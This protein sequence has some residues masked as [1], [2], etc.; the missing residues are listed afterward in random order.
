VVERLGAEL[1]DL[2]G[3]NLVGLYVYGSLAFGCYNPARS[4]VDVLV[5]TRRRMAAETLPTLSAFLNT[6]SDLEISFLSRADLDPWRLPCPY[7]Y[8]YSH[9]TE[10]HDGEN[11]DLAAEV[12]NARA[13]SVPLAGPPADSLLP[14]VPV[15][16]YLD[17]LVQDIQ[18][19][20][21][22]AD[23]PVYMVLNCCRALAFFRT[24]L[25]MSKLEGGEW[26]T[27]ELPR[28]FVPLAAQALNAYRSEPGIGDD[29]DVDEVRR[30]SKWVEAGL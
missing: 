21:A 2:L 10:K 9:S 3:P 14:E 19:A 26:A 24:R 16:D 25:L 15:E 5:V 1:P 27:R 22:R 18:W 4:D 30:F 20:G 28:E 6:F 8:H 7:D 11:P 23:I 29:L 17:C 12:T 13:R